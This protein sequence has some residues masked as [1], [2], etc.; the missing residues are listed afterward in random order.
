MNPLDL[1]FALL[2]A[3]GCVV[4][5]VACRGW[6]GACHARHNAIVVRNDALF[7]RDRWRDAHD[8]LLLRNAE[9]AADADAAKAAKR[10]RD[11]KASLKGWHTRRAPIRARAAELDRNV[12]A[13]AGA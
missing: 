9:K 7:S 6:R 11:S 10:D 2:G 8:G 13:R 1:A 12:A 3:A 4:A 5:I